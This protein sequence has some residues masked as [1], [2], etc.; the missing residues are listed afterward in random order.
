MR[1]ALGDKSTGY[2][3]DLSCRPVFMGSIGSGDPI[4]S[5]AHPTFDGVYCWFQVR[6]AARPR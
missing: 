5:D 3:E 6:G 1:E 4:D 2:P